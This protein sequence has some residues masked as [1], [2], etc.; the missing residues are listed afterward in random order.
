MNEKRYENGGNVQWDCQCCECGKITPLLSAHIRGTVKTCR[1]NRAVDLTGQVF[2]HLTVLSRIGYVASVKK[3]MNVCECSCGNIIERSNVALLDN[4]TKSCGCK[5][6]ELISIDLGGSGIPYENA[7]DSE[8]IRHSQEYTSWGSACLK[9]DG[10][11]CQLSGIRGDHVHH[12]Q[13]LSSIIKTYGITKENYLEYSNYLFDLSNGVTL[14]KD[15]HDKFHLLFGK[16]NTPEQ[17]SI[18][19]EG[20][21]LV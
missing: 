17:F 19:T 21:S 18:F 4:N 16:E 15:L 6:S 10:F 14:S 3:T 5:K 20:L 9:R 2:G 7:E 12:K 11:K 13:S 8:F 1:C